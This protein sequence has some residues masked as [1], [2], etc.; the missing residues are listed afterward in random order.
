MAVAGM[1]NYVV[2]SDKDGAIKTGLTLLEGED[3]SLQYGWALSPAIAP[4]VSQADVGY[5]EYNPEQELVW[6]QYDW[7]GG[8]LLYYYSV[9]APNR[10]GLTDKVWPITPSEVSLGPDAVPVSFGLRNG[11]AELGTNGQWTASGVTLTAVTTEPFSGVYHFQLASTSTNDYIGQNLENYARWVNTRVYV[12]AK[13]RLASGS[14]GTMRMQ[15]VESGG[16][17]TPTT[18]G[19][20]VTLSTTYQL[21]SAYVTTQSDSTAINVRVTCV[22]DGGADKTIYVDEIQAHATGGS[23]TSE[24]M[25]S[26]GV[27]MVV[28]GADL[29]AATQNGL[30]KFNDTYDHFELQ[31][32]FTQ[33]ITGLQVYEGR[34]YVGLGESTAYQYS[35]AGDATS[36]TAASGGGN[37]ANYFSRVQNANANWALVK[38]LNDDD[39][40]LS[41]SPTGSASWG[42]AIEAGNDDHTINNV[43]NVDGTLAI[44]KQDGLYRY[45]SLEGNQ[46]ANVYPGAESAVDSDNFSRG[47]TY[48]GRFYTTFSEV[49]L[50]RYDG[51]Y[52]EDLSYLIESPGFSDFGN[53]V[54]AFGT[55]GKVLYIVV[56]DL[57]S[58]GLTKNCWLFALQTFMDGTT[59][60]HPLSSLQL[61]DAIDMTVFKPSG[62]N[63][64]YLFVNGQS[65]ATEAVAYRFTLPDKSSTPRLGTNKNM[66][67]SG[68][69]VTSYWDGARPQ[70][71]KAFNRLTLVTESLSSTETITVAY[72]VDNDTSWTN[73]N[74]EN[75]SVNASPSGTLKFNDGVVGRRIRLR[76][77]LTTSAATATPVLKGFALHTSWRPDRLKTWRM[78][79]GLDSAARNLHGQRAM[80]P[81]AK[82]L[83]NLE[84]LRAETSPIKFEDIDG[85]SHNAHIVDMAETQVRVRTGTAGTLQYSRA[86]NLVM[87]EVPGG[88][89]G[90]IRWDAFNWG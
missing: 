81:M 69:F 41:T 36:W 43:F 28:M 47:I 68:T 74:S 12:T 34:I 33:D 32:N 57:N 30:Y 48:N 20:T 63:N 65:T 90:F 72:Q 25:N 55:D 6:S 9:D 60:V 62:A 87:T 53:R 27:R 2:L 80:L 64:R 31:K 82:M 50:L 39:V 5:G 37:K 71:T 3:G 22:S 56:E 15:I 75:A 13:V 7:S 18:S 10:Y 23:D 45:L 24:P 70:V 54:R 38:T 77:T 79:A 21:L 76:F 88:G 4:T 85:V 19:D 73:V 40:H 42:S 11:G 66:A 35:D 78:L 67:L 58:A 17:S 84:A 46:F 51:T 29:F 44:G 86:L 1:S 83:S 26:K 59:A 16:S 49:G 61:S 14:G 52:W 8:G 89:W